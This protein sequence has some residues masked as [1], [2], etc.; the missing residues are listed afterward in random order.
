MSF[1]ESPTPATRRPGDGP[2]PAA[3]SAAV[4]VTVG[5]T[6]A[7]AGPAAGIPLAVLAAALGL[8]SGRS[9]TWAVV[10]LAVGLRLLASI[11]ASREDARRWWD[12]AADGAPT[13]FA[14][15]LRVERV[16]PA[17]K[18]RWSALGVATGCPR[19]CPGARLTWQGAGVPPRAGERREVVGRLV[20]DPPR[21][22][23]GARYPPEGIGPGSLRGRVLD[24][25]TGPHRT[26]RAPGL[27][28]L[29]GHLRE[30]MAARFGSAL[31]PL[32]LALLLGDRV[33]LDP[34]LS[35]AFAASGTLHLLAVSGLQVGFL[36]AILHLVLGLAG[37]APRPKAAATGLLLAVYTALVGAPASIVR[38]TLMAVVVLW[39]R[40]DERRISGWQ[41]WGLAV[42]LIL[43][44]RPLDLLDLGF[45]LSFAA[46][47]G[48]LAG[49][50]LDRALAGGGGRLRRVLVGGLLA[51]TAS[52]LGT[53]PIQAASFGWIAPAGLP[54]NPFAVPLS[55]MALPV[56][57]MSL[58]ADATGLEALAAPLTRTAAATLAALETAVVAGGTRAPVWVPG[59]AGWTVG[60]AMLLA[61]SLV[62]AARWPR[63]ALAAAA[64]GL[65][66][67]L[68]TP[69]RPFRG[70]EV[71][72][73]DVGQGDA[74]VIH[75]PDR[76]TWLVDA[77]PAYPFGDAGRSVVLP[78]LRR[79][80][81]SRLEWLIVTHPDLD[82]VGGAA[83]V[84]RGVEVGRLASPMAVDDGPAWLELLA[85]T[86]G[87]RPRAVTLRAGQRLRQG[88]VSIDV[89]HPTVEWVPVDPYDGRRSSNESSAVLLMSGG[90][91]RLLLTG[92]LGE[93][94][95]RALV[96]RL[97][98]SLRAGLLHVGHHGSRHS[99]SAAFL[100]KVAPQAAVVSVGRANRHGHP[101]PDALT[102]LAAAG[103]AV[104]R[105]D[106]RGPVFARCEVGGWRLSTPGSYLRSRLPPGQ[107]S[108]DARVPAA[109]ARNFA[110][111]APVSHR[112]HGAHDRGADGDVP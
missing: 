110:R 85:T 100:A 48:L 62:A 11:D 65:A 54:V 83:S 36:A 41:A 4:L 13:P 66:V 37:L 25:R 95:E 67:L 68:A 31:E 30:R 26:G 52:T 29:E 14:A 94:G 109:G 8:R 57:W 63:P 101:H 107:A 50:P 20:A 76:A 51:T 58:L 15:V 90:P 53:M 2:A 21:S 56:L 77:G 34:A 80:G 78:Y 87:D 84:V 93:P 106:R 60:A 82:H 105:T 97:A 22:L 19:P 43:A 75:F 108:H 9:R 69:G 1:V 89:L 18:D 42:V 32:A 28:L 79:R 103:A 73:L 23:T 98:D 81:V 86:T 88:S 71:G 72:W 59:E 24:A 49:A 64:F 99:S 33:D 40:A 17:G 16:R 91:C 92:D 10:T 7:Y 5:L 45:A 112:R 44:W 47:A 46:V 61:V 12:R 6:G 3:I 102:R 38:G 74:V 104:W 111:P 39:A 55:C 96:A 70:W 35:D 27:S